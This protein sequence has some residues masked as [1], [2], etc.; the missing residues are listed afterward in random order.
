[1]KLWILKNIK[2]NTAF[3]EV[4]Y[5][6]GYN[7]KEHENEIIINKKQSEHVYIEKKNTGEFAIKLLDKHIEVEDAKK[8]INELKKSIDLLDY[9]DF[10]TK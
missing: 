6:N 10:M 7:I 5:N 2:N 4:F 3:K 8:I 1:M 9:I